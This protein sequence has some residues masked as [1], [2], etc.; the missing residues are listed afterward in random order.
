LVLVLVLVLVRAG[1]FGG[2]P[3]S[4]QIKAW[5][6]RR[7]ADK[8]FALIEK[9]Q[10][11]DAR[12][13]AVGALQLSPDEPEALRAV[14]RFLSRT[15]QPDALEFWRRLRDKHDLTRTDLRDEATIA[16]VAGEMGRADQ[17]LQEL[18]AEKPSPADWIL[19]AQ[20][21]I[22]NGAHR[23]ARTAIETINNDAGAP[24]R[25]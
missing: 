15:R 25:E 24:E 12:G 6:A 21:A 18:L 10:W 7:H 9:E 4:H 14:A 1:I 3:L 19:A 17:A 16:L 13:E 8:A 23:D 5:Q 11:N 20:L 22:R 2:R